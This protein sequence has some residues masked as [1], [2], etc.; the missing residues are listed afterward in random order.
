[1]RERH[2]RLLYL[3]GRYTIPVV[4]IGTVSIVLA[5]VLMVSLREMK[6]TARR[7]QVKHNLRQVGLAM[8]SYNSMHGH[9]PDG[10]K[11]N[12]AQE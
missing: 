9:Y 12:G 11:V 10:R 6:L 1:M 2:A 8:E 3:L 5:V 4:V 7:Q